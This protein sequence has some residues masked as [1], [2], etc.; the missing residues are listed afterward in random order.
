MNCSGQHPRRPEAAPPVLPHL[1]PGVDR[2]QLGLGVA[3][4]PGAG[5]RHLV[6]RE[7]GVEAGAAAVRVTRLE[8]H[9]EA[10]WR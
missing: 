1:G 10:L 8:A 2:Q 6:L 9:S 4:S 7:A 3:A 5:H